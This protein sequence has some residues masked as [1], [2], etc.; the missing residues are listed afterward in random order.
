VR[1]APRLL[2]HRGLPAADV[3][4]LE[5]LLARVSMLVDDLT[6]VA[7]VSLNPVIVGEEGLCVASA[8]LEVGHPVR[9]DAGR[10]S[11]PTPAEP[12]P[13]GVGADGPVVVAD[14]GRGAQD[15]DRG[16]RVEQ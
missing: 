3:A 5:D 4:A 1:A 6:E 16:A 9:Q 11:L 7:E 8:V 12:G 13:A 2:G 14:G 15:D 10:R